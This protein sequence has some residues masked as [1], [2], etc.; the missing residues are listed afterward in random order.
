MSKPTKYYSDIQENM[1][2]DYLNWHTVVGSGATA[3]KPGD[4]QSDQ[5]LGECKT[6]TKKMDK[7]VFRFD[8]WVKIRKEAQS[9][10]KYPVLF[11]DNG[12]QKAECTFCLIDLDVC[13]LVGAIFISTDDKPSV[14]SITLN[15]SV[16]SHLMTMPFSV[17]EVKFQNT[18]LAGGNLGVISLDNF[19][20]YII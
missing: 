8:H 12:T 7:I 4:I 2:A 1:I 5:W 16:L 6:H 17:L 18:D 3:T 11:T 15:K 10:F 14:S 20:R 9:K 13:S 19:R